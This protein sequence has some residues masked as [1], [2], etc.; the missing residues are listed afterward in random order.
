MDFGERSAE[1]SFGVAFEFELGHH[2]VAEC[3]FHENVVR[4][5]AG[6]VLQG[7]NHAGVADP[8][9]F[10]LVVQAVQEFF[11]ALVDIEEVLAILESVASE[12][13]CPPGHFLTGN[14]R[15]VLAFPVAKVDFDDLVTLFDREVDYGGCLFC[16]AGAAQQRAGEQPG[17]FG[18]GGN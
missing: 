12:V 6:E 13:S 16:Q 8:E 7:G 14:F 11:H 10:A 1:M 17:R 18:V 4:K 5:S 3:P 2:G 9:K 15:K